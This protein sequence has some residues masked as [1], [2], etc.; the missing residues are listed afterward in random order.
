[1]L[2]HV[3]NLY[4][5]E[6]AL[7]GRA[8]NEGV[9]S[10]TLHQSSPNATSYCSFFNC[11]ELVAIEPDSAVTIALLGSRAEPHMYIIILTKCGSDLSSVLT[12]PSLC[13]L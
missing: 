12:L 2:V 7:L 9:E 3:S 5:L 13:H 1:M 8:W 10:R 4:I 6:D 11:C